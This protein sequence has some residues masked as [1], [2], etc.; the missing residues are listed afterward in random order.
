M[1]PI[2]AKA[3]DAAAA[4]AAPNL[5]AALA[6]TASEHAAT[7]NGTAPGA[8]GRS[9]APAAEAVGPAGEI[10][11]GRPNRPLAAVAA[12]ASAAAQAA[13]PW[14]AW[15]AFTARFLQAD[16]RVID[17]SSPR[18]HTVSEGQAYALFFALS[19]GDR[20]TFERI[21][22]WTEDNLAAGDLALRL[23]A[24]QWGR[25]DDGS[26][27]VLD[28]NSASDADLWLAYALAEAGRLWNERRYRALSSLLAERI[29]REETAVIPG[30]GRT[31]LP[32]AQG[33]APAAG[34]WRLNPSYTPPFLMRWFATHSG[35]PRWRELHSTAQRLLVASSPAGVAPDWAY[36][37]E[38]ALPARVADDP[39]TQAGGFTF[40]GLAAADRAGAY[41]AIRVYLWAAMTSPND[42]D[43]AALLQHF[44]RYADLADAL[45]MPPLAVDAAAPAPGGPQGPPGFA[46]ALLPLLKALGRPA[47][48]AAVQTRLAAAPPAADAYYDQVLTLF[49]R[50]WLEGRFA[51]AADGSLLTGSACGPGAEVP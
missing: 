21:L 51:F 23:P 27:D 32:G 10:D 1:L 20:P 14:P 41:D 36:F 22:R 39:A 31:L 24:W 7:P 34:R 43:A 38:P 26:Y 17:P 8:P 40:A 49:G 19:Q 15:D 45:G 12:G 16:G 3:R 42:P 2:P 48:V 29:L 44:S 5:A 9:P 18:A 6:T 46:A 35:D 4:P 50:G 37:D 28:A 33:F 47:A 30:L 11:A 13:C 25:R